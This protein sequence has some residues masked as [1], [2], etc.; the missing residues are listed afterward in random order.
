MGG[1]RQ[2]SILRH[3]RCH[4]GIECRDQ[5]PHLQSNL[6]SSLAAIDIDEVVG[7]RLLFEHSRSSTCM[8]EW[9]HAAR[10]VARDPLRVGWLPGR[11]GQLGELF[12]SP[13][14]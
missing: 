2:D 3:D 7:E 9:A 4:D 5:V 1:A 11:L 13:G 8:A 12:G 10:L 14:A 6:Q